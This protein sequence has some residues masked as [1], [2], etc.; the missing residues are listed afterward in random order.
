MMSRH[1]GAA[2][3]KEGKQGPFLSLELDAASVMADAVS[4]LGRGEETVTYFAFPNQKKEGGKDGQPDHRLV[5]PQ[6]RAEPDES[7][8]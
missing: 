2:W 8:S 3:R 4:A 6:R 5:R 1:V 7:L